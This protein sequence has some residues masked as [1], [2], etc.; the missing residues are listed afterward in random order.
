MESASDIIC[1]VFNIYQ[2][3]SILDFGERRSLYCRLSQL[4]MLCPSLHYMYLVLYLVDGDV[5]DVASS[6]LSTLCITP[7]SPNRHGEQDSTTCPLEFF[8][9][10]MYNLI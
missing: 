4:K 7:T 5:V 3:L 6:V 9:P 10:I 8:Q 1:I 2:R